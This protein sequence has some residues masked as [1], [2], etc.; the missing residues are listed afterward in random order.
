MPFTIEQKKRLLSGILLG[1]GLLL[2]F[3]YWTNMQQRTEQAGAEQESWVQLSEQE[4][5]Q[6]ALLEEEEEEEL[7][8]AMQERS[9]AEA[10][11]LFLRSE[12]EQEGERLQRPGRALLRHRLDLFFSLAVEQSEA[13]FEL[14]APK[15]EQ[16]YANGKNWTVAR[17]RKSVLS[18]W[19]QIE[20]EHFEIDE[21]SI[22]YTELADGGMS[23]QFR[24]Y[25]EARFFSEERRAIA[26]WYLGFIVFDKQGL[27]RIFR[28]KEA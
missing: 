10:E 7:Q 27:I 13:Y 22:A 4:E 18:W 12:Y 2:A 26:G 20:H 17:L 28:A 25:Y 9:E 5:R 3:V 23:M 15:V 11:E 1:G 14:F 24:Y 16:F 21:Q 19:K 8:A 6:E